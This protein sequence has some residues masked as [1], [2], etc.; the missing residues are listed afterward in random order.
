MVLTAHQVVLLS[1]G[2]FLF[3]HFSLADASVGM[4]TVSPDDI[5]CVGTLTASVMCVSISLFTLHFTPT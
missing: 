3:F 2:D 1:G 5:K 4:L